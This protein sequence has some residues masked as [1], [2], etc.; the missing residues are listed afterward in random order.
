MIW[1]NGHGSGLQDLREFFSGPK[2][3]RLLLPKE[4]IPEGRMIRDLLTPASHQSKKR[5]MELLSPPRD[6]QHK[7]IVLI[8]WP[9]KYGLRGLFFSSPMIMTLG[10]WSRAFIGWAIGAVQSA[11]GSPIKKDIERGRERLKIDDTL[12]L[13]VVLLRG[14]CQVCLVSGGVR[15]LPDAGAGKAQHL[16]RATV[17]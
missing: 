15:W 16:R 17:H 14:S 6:V 7:A 5:G 11:G 10:H 9:I 13:A 8:G 4:N 1:L 2:L 12:Q 3:R